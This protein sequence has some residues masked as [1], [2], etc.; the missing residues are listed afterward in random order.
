MGPC[1]TIEQLQELINVW[2]KKVSTGGGSFSVKRCGAN[3]A[4]KYR[5]PQ[6]LIMCSRGGTIRA[7]KKQQQPQVDTG[8]SVVDQHKPSKKTRETKQHSM[9]IQCPWEIWAEETTEGWYIA[10]PTDKAMQYAIEKGEEVCLCHNHD[11]VTTDEGKLAFSALREIPKELEEYAKYLNQCGYLSQSQ[12]YRS[13]VDQCMKEG[14][15]QTFTLSDIRNKYATPRN[16]AIL[17]CSHL[18]ELYLLTLIHGECTW[19]VVAV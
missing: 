8:E 2:A 7:P 10:Y 16:E 6:K 5:G 13:L 14:I 9:I 4:T 19:Y 1:Q 12:I 3:A 11:L 18:A 15:T 17:D